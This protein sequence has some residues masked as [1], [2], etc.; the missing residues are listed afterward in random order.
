MGFQE[1]R[2]GASRVQAIWMGIATTAI[3]FRAVAIR[4]RSKQRRTRKDRKSH[5]K[6][7]NRIVGLR[8][9]GILW[10]RPCF[11]TRRKRSSFKDKRNCYFPHRVSRSNYNKTRISNWL[12]RR[13]ATR[14]RDNNSC[15]NSCSISRTPSL[16]R[17]RVCRRPWAI[18]GCRSWANK[19]SR[20][21]T[22]MGRIFIYSLL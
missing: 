1:E 10:P 19:S 3:Q 9:W 20:S 16:R 22:Q 17:D 7:I 11:R 14:I 21:K 12:H 6:A 15:N 8:S 4:F 2:P 5:S 18:S 13:R